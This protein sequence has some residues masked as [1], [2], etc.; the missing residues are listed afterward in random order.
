MHPLSPPADAI[1]LFGRACSVLLLVGLT[2]RA[3][4][5][6]LEKEKHDEVR[7]RLRLREIFPF[8]VVDRAS[9]I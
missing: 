8:T 5:A 4:T 9:V 7:A 2:A 1:R 6:I 3:L